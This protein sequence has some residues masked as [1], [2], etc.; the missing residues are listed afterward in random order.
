MA[1]IGDAWATNAWVEASWVDGAWFPGVS[2]LF[3][4]T[5]FNTD[6]GPLD[7]I[8]ALLETYLETISDTKTLHLI[9]IERLS[10]NG[11]RGTIIHDT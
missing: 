5:R 6:S 9:D 11:Y 8:I 7:K 2:V 10:I 4:L 1:A 3:N